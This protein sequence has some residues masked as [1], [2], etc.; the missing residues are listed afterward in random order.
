MSFMSPLLYNASIFFL[1]KAS[2]EWVWFQICDREG[3]RATP[4]GHTA[5]QAS[6]FVPWAKF[7]V[8]RLA[9]LSHSNYAIV[10]L[11]FSFTLIKHVC[12]R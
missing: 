7:L 5:S 9:T 10:L 4:Q 6:S 8:I 11:E 2:F 12:I 1:V 3:Q